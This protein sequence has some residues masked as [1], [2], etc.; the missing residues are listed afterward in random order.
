M[1]I[2]KIKGSIGWDV[3]CAIIENQIERTSGDITFE[4]DSPGG[5]FHQGLSLFNKIKNYNRGNTTAYVYGL[6]ASMATYLAMACDKILF[7]QNAVWVIHNVQGAVAGNGNTISEYG[8][9]LKK[10][11]G[12][13]RSAYS[14]RINIPEEE[15]QLL[16]DKETRYIGPEE[17]KIWGEVV[18]SGKYTLETG[19][20]SYEELQARVNRQIEALNAQFN[21]ARVQ[22]K[23]I[24]EIAAYLEANAEI[25]V[26]NDCVKA[27]DLQ[28]DRLIQGKVEKMDKLELKEKYPQIYAQI[29]EEGMKQ[30]Q[31]LER[32]RVNAHLKFV[33]VNRDVAISAIQNG[34]PFTDEEVQAEYLLSSV[35]LQKIEAMEQQNPDS[36]VTK[37]PVQPEPQPSGEVTANAELEA[38]LR[39]ELNMT[40]E[41][42]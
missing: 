32:K 37:E 3:D 12:I 8:E 27:A 2:I 19:R 22:K 30:G 31:E 34:K 28:N 38:A 21:T 10:Y 24:E 36:I 33:E 14:S 18:E 20:L 41:G 4:I 11:S 42:I 39:A 29:L 23:E 35:N 5:L 15:I 40:K 7:E 6:C 1:K 9:M 16:M 13:L 26:L 17:L 25:P